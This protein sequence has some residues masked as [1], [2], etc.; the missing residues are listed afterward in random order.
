[1]ISKL[2]L[3]LG[4]FVV[5]AAGVVAFVSLNH[6]VSGTP[7]QQLRSWVS[8]TNLGQDIGTLEGDGTDVRRALAAGKGIV[9]VHTICAA[10]ITAE[11]TYGDN[12]PSPDTALTQLLAQA[13]TLEFKSA[14]S[15]YRA[16]STRSRS[17]SVSERDA[18]SAAT[19]FGEVVRRVRSL[20]GSTVPT[21][22]T[23]GPPVT[24]GIL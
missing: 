5:V 24:T 19:L 2:W 3:G 17:I 7:A 10:M 20:T 14:E 4:A 1:M 23:T 9:A 13:Y 22:T 8:S 21:T 18:T 11:G 16:S 6:G 12:L 15:C